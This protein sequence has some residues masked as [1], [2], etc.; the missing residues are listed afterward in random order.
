MFDWDFQNSPLLVRGM[1]DLIVGSGKTGTV[2]ALEADSGK[3]VWRAKVGKHENDELK[4]LPADTSIRIL[5]GALGGVLTAL[6]YASGVIY[7]PVVNLPTDYNGS[8]FVPDLP[9]R[10]D[11]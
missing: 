10:R 4:E 5:P 8:S 1:P 2:V 11:H 9:D 7:V 6:A 3:F